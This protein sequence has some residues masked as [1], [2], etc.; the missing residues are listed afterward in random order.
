MRS[1]APELAKASRKLVRFSA[2]DAHGREDRHEPLLSQ[3]PSTGRDASR[4]LVGWQARAGEDGQ[5]L[6]ADE[7]G[8]QVDG[9]DAGLDEVLGVVARGWVDGATVHVQPAQ[10]NDGRPVVDGPASPIEH[11]SQHRAGDTQSEGVA[12]ELDLHRLE[13]K[14]AGALVDLDDGDVL[15]ELGDLAVA[16]ACR[17]RHGR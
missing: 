10:R 1:S 8:Q 3:Q 13:V 9:A 2:R 17:R 6:A 11:A 15:V 7:R 4:E 14:A 12:R 5:L 16:N